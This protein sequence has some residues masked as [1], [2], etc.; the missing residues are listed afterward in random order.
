[1]DPQI[2]M[3]GN[4]LGVILLW[5]A[6]IVFGLLIVAKLFGGIKNIVR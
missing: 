5:T 4:N 2:A 1:M 3:A 6:G